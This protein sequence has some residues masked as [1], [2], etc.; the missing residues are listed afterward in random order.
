MNSLHTLISTLEDQLTELK[1]H[2]AKDVEVVEADV[3]KAETTVRAEL[4]ALLA[5]LKAL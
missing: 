4:Q 2:A 1:E 3:A 5:K